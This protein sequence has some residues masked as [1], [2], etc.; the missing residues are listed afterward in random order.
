MRLCPGF[1]PM[2]VPILQS[3]EGSSRVPTLLLETE[4]ALFA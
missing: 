4:L 1:V 3:G 2:R